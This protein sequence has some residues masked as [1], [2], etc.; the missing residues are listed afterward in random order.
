MRISDWSS[1]VC[2]SDLFRIVTRTTSE[3]E[4][5]RL[6]ELGQVQF[7]VNVPAG[8][9]REVSRGARPALLVEADATDPAATSNALGVLTALEQ[10]GLDRDLTGPRAHLK[11]D[12]TPVE[13]RVH[14]LY[15]PEEIGRA[16]V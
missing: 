13:L 11:T 8:F 9:G 12:A 2:S 4:A 3:A 10:S 1:D 6:L 7:V 16:H 15:N 14:R 5:R